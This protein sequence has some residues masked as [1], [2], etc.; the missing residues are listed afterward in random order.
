MKDLEN[1]LRELNSGTQGAQQ[2]AQTVF[3]SVKDL[4]TRVQN[5]FRRMRRAT[6]TQG[7]T[8]PLQNVVSQSAGT[9]PQGQKSLHILFCIEKEN[10]GTR[11]HQA[12][13]EN[14]N[15]DRE[16]F[17]LL[18]EEYQA[19]RNTTSWLTLRSIKKLSLSRVCRMTAFAALSWEFQETNNLLVSYRLEQLGR[20]SLAL[21][22]LQGGLCLSTT[23]S[24][25]T[26][27]KIRLPS[28][29]RGSL[30]TQTGHWTQSP[31]TLLSKPRMPK[32]KS[33]K[34]LQSAAQEGG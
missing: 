26:A 21:G 6:R 34:H 33:T 32:L 27:E 23:A 5:V 22:Y 24:S 10:L 12:C 9:G 14:I 17:Q 16:T 31:E 20:C 11:L 4:S 2:L 29:T 13:V 8:L 3:E 25:S 30:K 18:R 1:H 15:T 28:S 7:T 19:R